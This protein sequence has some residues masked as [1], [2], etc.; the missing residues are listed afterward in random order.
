M[1]TS[2]RPVVLRNGVLVED[3]LSAVLG[4]AKAFRP[5]DV[6]DSSRSASFGEPDL[7]LANR[8]GARI[9]AAEIAAVL[10]RRRAIERALEAVGPGSSLAGT[11]DSVP[12]LLL[13]QLFDAF[14]GI[15]GV[16]LAK[17]TKALHPK[18]PALI[19][20]L[21]SVVQKYLQDEDLGAQAAFGERALGL[22]R[23]YKSDLDRNGPTLR[24]VQ[25]ELARR[26]YALTEVRILDLLILSAAAAD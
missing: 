4:L 18:R 24:A 17:M 25:Q 13:R 23:G 19:P 16:G 12:W 11:A 1:T 21:N 6:G 2:F 15:R 3:P 22:V 14:A 9:S 8:G 7:R 10:E 20:L 26:S 5:F